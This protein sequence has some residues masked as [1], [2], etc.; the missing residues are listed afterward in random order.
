MCKIKDQTPMI[1]QQYKTW[2]VAL[3]S[4]CYETVS[5]PMMFL[6]TDIA[7]PSAVT[8]SLAIL[9]ILGTLLSASAFEAIY[10]YRDQLSLTIDNRDACGYI[11]LI[12]YLF[13]ANGIGY[14]AT[15]SAVL[16]KNF[17]KQSN[18]LPVYNV[19]DV[20]SVLLSLYIMTY[21]TFGFSFISMGL[22]EKVDLGYLEN[23]KGFERF[24]AYYHD[25]VKLR[26]SDIDEF[27]HSKNKKNSSEDILQINGG[28]LTAQNANALDFEDYEIATPELV[29]VGEPASQNK[30][31]LK[32]HEITPNYVFN[33][34]QYFTNLN[35]HKNVL[36]EEPENNP[37]DHNNPNHTDR[38]GLGAKKH[39]LSRVSNVFEAAIKDNTVITTNPFKV[40]YFMVQVFIGMAYLVPLLLFKI[41][42]SFDII[43]LFVS[44]LI[45]KF[46]GS[47]L[48][49][50][51]SQ[52][53]RIRR[54]HL[55][56]RQESII[57]II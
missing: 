46:R 43:T 40:S 56:S 11:L 54:R 24:H 52:S 53:T 32:D 8:A 57:S 14:L 4:L 33:K 45:S 18:P 39:K 3:I 28:I 5:T 47:I 36:H 9:M 51:S 41:Y 21:L 23:P 16:Y 30:R 25:S 44:F 26:H 10:L 13:M 38:H 17:L 34:N 29:S 35:F 12:N 15:A 7:D 6:L 2:I 42:K 27:D 55:Q 22:N 49:R 48:M 19:F 1:K 50:N 37:T 31:P 20:R